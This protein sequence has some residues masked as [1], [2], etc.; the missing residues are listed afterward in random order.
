[1][2]GVW[3]LRDG[4]LIRWY[5]RR[6]P[7]VVIT[8]TAAAAITIT[9]RLVKLTIIIPTAT[10]RQLQAVPPATTVVRGVADLEVLVR[11]LYQ[12]FILPR[13]V[14]LLVVIDDEQLVM[15]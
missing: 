5:D 10:R 3:L 2:R 12:V 6:W 13:G 8:T 7:I 14:V 11:I 15:L 1:M 9:I 4:R